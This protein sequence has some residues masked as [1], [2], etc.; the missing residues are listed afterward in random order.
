MT[1]TPKPQA[2]TLD[3]ILHTLE[4]V[5]IDNSIKLLEDDT[6][7]FETSHDKAHATAK[8]QLLAEVLDMIGGWYKYPSK[9]LPGDEEHLIAE[10]VNKVRAEYRKAAKERFK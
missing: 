7:E 1:N 4:E 9:A 2:N 3:E 10:T 5:V 6:Y 8:Q